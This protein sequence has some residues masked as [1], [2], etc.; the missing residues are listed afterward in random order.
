METAPQAPVSRWEGATSFFQVPW[1]KLMMW[2]FLLSDTLTFAGLVAGY[3]FLRAASETWPAQ[4]EIFNLG[5]VGFMT[6]VLI[7]SSATMAAAVGAARRGDPLKAGRLLGLTVAGGLLFLGMQG[8]EWT[9]FILEGARLGTNPWGVPLFSTTFFVI[10]GFH[11]FH[12]LA[13]VVY[14]TTVTYRTLQGRFGADGVESAGLYWHFVDLVWVFI[15]TF[16][17]LV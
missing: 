12:V 6:F 7:C 14:L 1:G 5:L 9:H 17:Y 3:G 11:G 2:L 15:F 4:G 8:Y 13:G 10:T 16:L